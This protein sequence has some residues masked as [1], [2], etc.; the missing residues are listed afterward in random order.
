MHEFQNLEPVIWEFGNLFLSRFKFR[1][2]LSRP[3]G[4]RT[5]LRLVCRYWLCSVE[6]CKGA[7]QSD[8]VSVWQHTLVG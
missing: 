5:A 8:L 7:K 4:F 1:G 6:F 3:A 2:H